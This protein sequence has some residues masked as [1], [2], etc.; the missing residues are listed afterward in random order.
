MPVKPRVVRI[1]NNSVPVDFI[2]FISAVSLFSFSQSVVN[3]IFNNFLNETF[4]ITNFQRGILEIPRELPGFL[5]VFVSALFFFLSGRRL[6][7]LAFLLASCGSI[8]LGLLSTGYG[9]MLGWLFIFSTGQHPFFRS[10]RRSAWSSR[11]REG[12]EGGL[13]SRP[14]R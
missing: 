1:R 12:P 2:L 11:R 5:V 14:A 4:T 9:A 7:A 8:L 13:A 3:T 10:T 6:A